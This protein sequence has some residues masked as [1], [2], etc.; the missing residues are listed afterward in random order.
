MNEMLCCGKL[1]M[2][3]HTI[4]FLLYDDVEEQDF[5]GPLEVF[6]TACDIAKK[7][8]D[9]TLGRMML[10]S[11]SGADITTTSGMS[12]SVECTL[13]H[14]PRLDVLFIP[15]GPGICSTIHNIE[16]LQEIA[17]IASECL[18]I[19]STGTGVFL[20][21]A[22][23]LTGN[24]KLATHRSARH[25]F[26]EPGLTGECIAQTHYIRDSNLLT[27]IGATAGIDMCLWLTGQ[28]YS[29]PLALAAQRALN[30]QRLPGILAFV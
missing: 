19:A 27:S 20:L 6:N 14:A 7:N 5:I 15:G 4:G 3:S 25:E 24:K 26:T 10:M 29:I 11:V 1:E 23:G 13:A 21:S 8:S 28:L 9:P 2:V 22:A 18:W 12:V 30:H 16:L 17:G